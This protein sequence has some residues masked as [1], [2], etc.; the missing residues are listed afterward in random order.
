MAI[1]KQMTLNV[2]GHRITV[3]A[4]RGPQ[5]FRTAVTSN[6]EDTTMRGLV[7]TLDPD[8]ALERAYV[9]YVKQL[10]S[11]NNCPYCGAD[12]DVGEPFSCC[13]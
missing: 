2:N 4:R 9:R 6:K 7:M 12:T 8:E 11:I 1:T 5:G 3:K 10:P 13:V